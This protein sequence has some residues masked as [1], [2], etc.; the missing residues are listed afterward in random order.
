[1]LAFG[2]VAERLAQCRVTTNVQ[3]VKKNAIFEQQR[4]ATQFFSHWDGQLVSLQLLK[5]MGEIEVFSKD[6]KFEIDI[7][8]RGRKRV[9]QENLWGLLS[10]IQGPTMCGG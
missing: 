7:T 2:N 6:G 9:D 1:M 10:N 4:H 5:W 3:F 8:Y